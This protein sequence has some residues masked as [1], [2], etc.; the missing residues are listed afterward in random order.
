MDNGRHLTCV[1]T[2]EDFKKMLNKLRRAQKVTIEDLAQ[3]SG[4]HRNGVAKIER[5]G[6]DPLLSNVLKIIE[7]LGG[8][9]YIGH[10]NVDLSQPESPAGKIKNDT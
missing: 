6:S 4:L 1:K 8:A 10:P 5:E 7:L 3:Y 9:V 2:P